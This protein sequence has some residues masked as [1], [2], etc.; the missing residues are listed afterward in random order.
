[1][2]RYSYNGPVL[3]FGKLMTDHWRSETMAKS[4]AKARNNFKYQYKVENNLLANTK[5]DMPG[6]I[7]II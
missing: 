3:I 7:H 2:N 4:K 6:D 5:I 1:M